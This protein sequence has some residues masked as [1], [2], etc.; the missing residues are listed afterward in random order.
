MHNFIWFYSRKNSIL[1]N[2][3][4]WQG[5]DA[6]YFLQKREDWKISQYFAGMLRF[7]LISAMGKEHWGGYNPDK[8]WVGLSLG[9]G[10][11]LISIAILCQDWV[12][13]II[14]L[15]L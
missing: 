2:D 3:R 11:F 10:A 7:G 6:W 14:G 4:F 5:V 15:Q 13:E 1:D 8:N 9:Q 12:T